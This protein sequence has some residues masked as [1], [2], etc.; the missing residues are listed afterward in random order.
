[1]HRKFITTELFISD[2]AKDFLDT[3]EKEF[4]KENIFREVWFN[5]KYT[6]KLDILKLV[7]NLYDIL[8]HSINYSSYYSCLSDYMEATF[9]V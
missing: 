1:M 6:S 9:L 5:F 7:F 2:R 4:E 8:G 3:D